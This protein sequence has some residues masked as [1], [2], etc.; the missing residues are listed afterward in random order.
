M[1]IR[2]LKPIDKSEIA[3]LHIALFGDEFP[4]DELVQEAADMFRADPNYWMTIVAEESPGKLCGYICGSIKEET[5]IVGRTRIGY[6]EAGRSSLSW[7]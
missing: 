7:H 5:P 1:T 3:R 2:P 6:V 4:Q